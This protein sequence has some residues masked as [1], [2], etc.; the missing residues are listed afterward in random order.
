MAFAYEGNFLKT[1]MIF[2][3]W[4]QTFRHVDWFQIWKDSFICGVCFYLPHIHTLVLLS[5]AQINVPLHFQYSS[6]SGKAGIQTICFL[7]RKARALPSITSL[8]TIRLMPSY[9]EGR[10]ETCAPAWSPHMPSC[11]LE[12]LQLHSEPLTRRVYN[13]NLARPLTIATPL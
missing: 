2:S 11:S 4:N 3:L 12:F 8:R 9:R 6:F 7:E 10:R 1:F 13:R 5:A